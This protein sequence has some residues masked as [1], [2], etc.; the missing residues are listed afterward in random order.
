MKAVFDTAKQCRSDD[1]FTL[2]ETLIAMMILA[3]SA[4]LLV[5]S[6]ALATGQIRT[7]AL[8]Q[9]AELLGV[10][11]LAEHAASTSKDPS[12]E[13][14]D[15]SSGLYW[16]LVQDR[17]VRKIDSVNRASAAFVVIE[18]RATKNSSPLY[19]LRSISMAADTQ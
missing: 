16:R 4:G 8:A 15:A 6:V 14:I 11:L 13:G 10:S 2:V 3:I 7:S 19:Q 9:A 1:G 12:A 17:Q 18:I 5:Q